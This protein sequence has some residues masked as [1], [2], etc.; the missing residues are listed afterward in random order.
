MRRPTPLLPALA[1]VLLLTACGSEHADTQGGGRGPGT[2]AS[3]SQ[4]SGPGLGGVRIT[5]ITIPS[6]SAAP[7]SAPGAFPT[8]DTLPAASGVS[9]A[10]EVT[11]RG[12]QT[13]TYTV[14]FDFTTGAGEV[15]SN[16]RETVRSVGPGRT[17]RGTV[18]LGV[19]PRGAARVTSVKV[20]E[21]TK[22]PTAEEPGVCTSAGIR[23]TADEGDAAMGLRV[24]GLRLENCGTGDYTLEGFPASSLLDEDH[25][26]VDGVEVLHGSGG[27][28]TV[29]GFDD[30][31]R[32]LTLKPGEYATASLMWR[33]T[34]GAGRAVNAPYVRL[35]RSPVPRR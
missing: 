17:V 4:V 3:P 33:N 14:L 31:P 22:V 8:L 5:A 18:A 1:A 10:Y 26:P 20:A 19:L 28:A 29:T 16:K 2:P 15:M 34:T 30:P 11:N 23:V 32:P 7:S 13:L 35:V 24:V 21:V 12:S 9:A 6:P 27:I 25:E